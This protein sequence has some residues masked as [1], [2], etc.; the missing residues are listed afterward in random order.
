MNGQRPF[1][2]KPAA[3]HAVLTWQ[4]F[5]LSGIG[6]SAAIKQRDYRCS[7]E[8]ACSHRYTEACPVQQLQKS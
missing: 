6:S 3:V 2:C 1:H 8:A 4:T 5:T 7:R